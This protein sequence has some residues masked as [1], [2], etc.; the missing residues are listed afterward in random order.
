MAISTKYALCMDCLNLKHCCLMICRLITKKEK[1]NVA[2]TL[3]QT[4]THGCLRCLQFI[5]RHFNDESPMLSLSSSTL[6]PIQ[7]VVRHGHLDCLRFLHE[8]SFPWDAYT[9]ELAIRSNKLDCLMYLIENKCPHNVKRM[10]IEAIMMDNTEIL[11]YV[12]SL[13]FIR[14]G[15]ASIDGMFL[16][17]LAVYYGSV[18]CMRYILS[19]EMC[20]L[21]NYQIDEAWRKEIFLTFYKKSDYKRLV[22]KLRTTHP[23]I[24]KLT[25][26]TSMST[27]VVITHRRFIDRNLKIRQLECLQQLQKVDIDPRYTILIKQL[28]KNIYMY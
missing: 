4:L 18:K 12:L 20:Q 19:D 7:K 17:F 16:C 27:N 1:I 22:H 25:S 5:F 24:G 21:R 2:F 11:R 26:S 9:C 6:Y 14:N 13:K 28:H 23:E 10:E 8:L 3:Q 15:T